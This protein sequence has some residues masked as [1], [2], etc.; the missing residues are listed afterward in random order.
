M[1]VALQNVD[2]SRDFNSPEEY[3][4]AMEEVE[5]ADVWRTTTTK[6]KNITCLS[7]LIIES[8]S[9]QKSVGTEK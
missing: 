5:V 1:F 6:S 9:Q 3:L 2:S 8:E 7:N 4:H